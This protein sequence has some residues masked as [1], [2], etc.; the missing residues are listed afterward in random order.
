MIRATYAEFHEDEGFP[1]HYIVVSHP[2]LDHYDGI[3][4]AT[5][6]R[7]KQGAAI[8]LTDGT[9]LNGEKVSSFTGHDHE[10]SIGT[11]I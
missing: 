7:G 9:N 4:N 8:V 10:P 2:D 5:V 11:L 6:A 1:L 3:E